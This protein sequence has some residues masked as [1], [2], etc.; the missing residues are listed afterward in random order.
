MPPFSLELLTIA[1]GSMPI[2]EGKGAVLIALTVFKFSLL[3]G[4][5]LAMLGNVLGGLAALVFL[6]RFAETTRHRS[7]IINRILT[8]IFE[9]TRIRHSDDFHH[10]KWATIALFIFVLTPVPL[11]GVWSGAVA[12]MLFGIPFKKAAIALCAGAFIST[13]FFAILIYTGVIVVQATL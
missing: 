4:F 12:A 5:I 2:T 7:H 8:W 11:T 1:L 9:R 6:E 3:K 13:A 10:W